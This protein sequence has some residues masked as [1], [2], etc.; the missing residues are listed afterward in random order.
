[1]KILINILILFFILFFVNILLYSTNIEYKNFIKN[2]KTDPESSL[3]DD[4]YNLEDIDIENKDNEINKAI[5]ENNLEIDSISNV[6]NTW[7]L[8]IDSDENIDIDAELEILDNEE[9][10]IEEKENNINIIEE[11]VTLSLLDKNVLS[12]FDEMNMSESDYFSSLFDITNE[13][14]EEFIEYT[15]SKLDLIFFLDQEYR[16][17]VDFFDVIS[18]DLPFSIKEVNNFWDKSFYIN[19]DNPDSYVRIVYTVNN[20]TYWLKILKSEYNNIKT[21]LTK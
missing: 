17:I 12:L 19:L 13:Y 15:S 8:I 4:E 9:K 5:D 1:M 20:R 2:L 18:F 11:V 21:I 14:P 10:D 7:S 16:K 6:E 3:L